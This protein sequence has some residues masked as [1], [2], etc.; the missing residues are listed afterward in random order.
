MR[1]RVRTALLAG[2][3]AVL[4]I[5]GIGCSS[6]KPEPSADVKGKDG[7]KAESKYAKKLEIKF[8]G[9][10]TK[11][12]TE[13]GSWVQKKLED[14]FNVKIINT[15][16]DTWNKDQVAL[17]IASGDLPDT[18]AFT[19]N[20]KTPREMYETGMTRTIP[21][22]MIV[23][24]A[25]K[26]AKMLDENPPGW[27]INLASGKTDEYVA[28]TGHQT[29]TE[30]LLWTPTFRLDWLEKL[31]IKPPGEIKAVGPSGGRERI[32]FTDKAYT[33][34]EIE[35]I[36][37]AFTFNDPD[38]NGKNDTYG[39]S[40][41]N[42]AYDTWSATLMGAFGIGSGYS[43]L[44]D[45]KLIMA[46]TSKAYKD[47]LK[48]LAKWYKMGVID[49]EWTTLNDKKS[50]EK[51]ATGKIGYYSAQRAY[52]ALDDWAKERAPQNLVQ[53]DQTV[54]LLAT[55]PEIGPNGQQ[56]HKSYRPVNLLGDAFYINKNVSDEELIRIL[57]MFDYI[58]FDEEGARWTKYGEIGTHSVWE[59]T[60]DKSALKV[61]E[62]FTAEEGSTGFYAYSFRSYDKKQLQYFTS[63]Y[64]MNLI[65]DFFAKP[66]VMKK[67]EIRPYKYDLL[68]Q[69]KGSDVQKKYGTQLSTIVEEF[70]MKAI[71][72]QLDIDKE[73]DGYVKKWTDAGGAQLLQELDKA[74][75]VEDL[76]KMK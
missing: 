25:P 24:Y 12:K 26:Y 58:N 38:G 41:Y 21:K 37:M 3:T 36:L 14:M 66:D 70:R 11:G 69:T 34:E 68:D 45:N 31:G 28:L 54:K 33:L 75:K 40:P 48:L 22:D 6:S 2:V 67:M 7:E 15:K 27:Q 62:G 73:W 30:G 16:V 61:K 4:A 39:L 23:K 10:W 17:L 71:V 74:P 60:P 76:L 19:A 20:S 50:W 56:G 32:Y 42:N 64:T 65:R 5:G 29:H 59:G 47:Y 1:K 51:Y 9:S 46:E 18:F 44:E 53:K 72:G 57:Q 52:I 49:P 35:K 55:A 8:T 13:D 63:E 43:L